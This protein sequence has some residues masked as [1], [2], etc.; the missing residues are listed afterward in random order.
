[1]A[2]VVKT[3]APSAGWLRGTA[4]DSIFIFGI[5]GVALLSGAAVL[6][7]PKLFPAILVLDLWLLGY[8]H[9]VSTYTRLCFDRTSLQELSFAWSSDSLS[10]FFRQAWIFSESAGRFMD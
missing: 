7:E 2:S 8:H 5:A 4:F 10:G 9:V 6:H 1:M 3:A